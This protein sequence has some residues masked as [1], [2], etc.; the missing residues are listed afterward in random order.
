[1]SFVGSSNSPRFFFCLGT[2]TD[3]ALSRHP[4]LQVLSQ[5]STTVSGALGKRNRIISGSASKELARKK[6]IPCDIGGAIRVARDDGEIFST[7]L[8]PKCP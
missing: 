1:M 3:M 6:P 4:R 2:K 7:T 5:G 8:D